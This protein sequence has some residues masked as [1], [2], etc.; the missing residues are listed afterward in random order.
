MEGSEFLRAQAEPDGDRGARS[1]EALGPGSRQRVLEELS[2]KSSILESVAVAGLLVGALCSFQMPQKLL[3]T[4]RLINPVF[5]GKLIPKFNRWR[6]MAKT[7][8]RV[9]RLRTNLNVKEI[10]AKQTLLLSASL[11]QVEELE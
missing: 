2:Y 11:S 7:W 1:G 5:Y 9:I 8:R 4:G 10:E 6:P 3:G